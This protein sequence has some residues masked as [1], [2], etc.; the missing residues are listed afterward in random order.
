MK[1]RPNY[2]G[3]FEDINAARTWVASYVPWYN[4]Q[5]RHSGIALFTPAQVH[6]GAWAQSWHQRDRTHQAYYDAHPERFRRRPSTQPHRRNQHPRQTRTRPTPG[7][8][9]MT[10][11]G[12]FSPR[13]LYKIR[14]Y[15]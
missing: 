15:I 8:L 9:T 10:D 2:P 11:G 4:Q 13:V 12:G 7:S 6:S 14:I 3:T 1:H 5:H